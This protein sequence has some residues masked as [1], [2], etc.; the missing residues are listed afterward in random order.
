MTPATARDAGPSA[1]ELLVHEML[2]R[3]ADRWT[4]VAIDALEACGTLRFGQLR[5]RMGGISQKM[6]T[7]TLRQLERDGLVSRQVYPVVPPRVEYRLTRLGAGLGQSLCGIWTW[8]EQHLKDVER[9]RRAYD[10]G[11]GR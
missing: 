8:A 6:L 9:S 11:V 5:E 7:K 3:I 1:K 10:A 2:E 4:L